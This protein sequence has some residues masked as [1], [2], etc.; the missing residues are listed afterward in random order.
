METVRYMKLCQ[1]SI[2][3]YKINESTAQ[4]TYR[5]VDETNGAR[6]VSAKEPVYVEHDNLFSRI[7]LLAHVCVRV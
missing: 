2:E 5:A 1:F 4:A 3:L 7:S 6:A